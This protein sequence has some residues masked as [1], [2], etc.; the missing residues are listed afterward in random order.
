MVSAL[1][2]SEDKL[3][4][5]I[6]TPITVKNALGQI[7][8]NTKGLWDTG[9]VNSAI[10]EKAASILN[11]PVIR[12]T[13]VRGVHGVKEVNVYFVEI[14]LNNP[15]IT[16]KCLVTGCDE[17]SDDGK[18]DMLIGMNII[19][20]GDFSISNYEGKTTMSFRVP[21]LEKKDYVA[22]INEFNSILKKHKAWQ[23]VGNEI[24]PC[25][26]GKKWKNCHGKSIYNK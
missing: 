18:I 25:G 24:C 20:K 2:Y 6:I 22:E 8:L 15:T 11:L 21:P 1:T 12:K 17:L 4:D 14:V 9:A 13:N 26:T 3:V 16:V 10:T 19:S 23:K 7:S 5:R